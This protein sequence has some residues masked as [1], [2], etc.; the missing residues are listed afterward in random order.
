MENSIYI[1]LSRQVA[2]QTNMDIIANNV[3]NANTTGFRAQNLLFDEF[4][5]DPRGADDELSFVVDQG[6]YQNTAPGSIKTTGNDLDIALEGPGFIGIQGPGGEIAYTRD[7]HF[8]KDAQGVLR[9]SSG[10]AV[11]SG[12]GGNVLIPQDTTSISIDRRGVVS[13]QDGV[14]GQISIT[15]FANVQELEPLGNN[16]YRTDAPANA[17]TQTTVHQGH[18][19]GSNVQTVIEVTRMIDTL[20]SFQ[21]VQKL[22]QSEGDRLKGMIERLTQRS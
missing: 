12:G 5:S 22:L 1:G 3:A 16:L 20:R 19:E 10:F 7:G 4:V 9:T 14:V 6:Q 8:E 11:A 15:E 18:L 21:N 2:L 13:N 17:A